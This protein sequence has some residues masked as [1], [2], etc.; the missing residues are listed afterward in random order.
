MTVYE[1]LEVI[2]WCS[3]KHFLIHKESKYFYMEYSGVKSLPLQ[4]VY[5]LPLS[6]HD[7]NLNCVLMLCCS[8]LVQN[9]N[10]FFFFFFLRS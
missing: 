6:L 7:N 2:S 5:R 1:N 8:Y 10:R 9:R 3:Q 4:H